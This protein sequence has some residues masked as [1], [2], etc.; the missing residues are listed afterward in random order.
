MCRTYGRVICSR[1]LIKALGDTFPHHL[2]EP[3]QHEARCAERLLRIATPRRLSKPCDRTALEALR[4][5]QHDLH[6]QIPFCRNWSRHVLDIRISLGLVGHV[7][8][9]A[10]ELVNRRLATPLNARQPC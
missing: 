6:L 4:A 1:G 3:D 8:L 10:L 7:V 5:I 2:H 9:A